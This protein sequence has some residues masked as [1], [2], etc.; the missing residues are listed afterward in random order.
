MLKCSKGFFAIEKNTIIYTGSLFNLASIF[1]TSFQ[2]TY[3]IKH[4]SLSGTPTC[5]LYER[6]F[7][8][9]CMCYQSVSTAKGTSA[10][11]AWNL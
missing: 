4:S 10:S 11:L 8:H 9:V 5:P 7:C 3:Y 6:Q 2:L 1:V